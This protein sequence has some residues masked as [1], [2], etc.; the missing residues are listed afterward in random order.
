M[1]GDRTMHND[2][3]LG[4]LPNFLIAGMMKCGTTAL[5]ECLRRHPDVFMPADEVHFFNRDKFYARGIDL[6]RATFAEWRGERAIG[7]KTPGYGFNPQVAA[8][9]A[10]TLPDVK[11][12]WI[13]RAP[14]ARA[15]SHYWF[16]AGQ[17]WERLSFGD[18][19]A[20][21]PRRLASTRAPLYMK[22]NHAYRTLG[23]YAQLLQPFLD[24]I[25]RERQLFLR[26]ED[27]A[28]AQEEF[29]ARIYAFLDL[30][31]HADFALP[32]KPVNAT[33][34]PYSIRLQWLVT[35]GLAR[36]FPKAPRLHV[37][38]FKTM[39]RINLHTT[40]GYPPLDPALRAE[41]DGY[42]APH[43]RA[44]RDLTGIEWAARPGA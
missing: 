35:R 29:L 36:L 42:Y 13:L 40:P 44:L 34:R 18:A 43:N 41:L 24:A 31:P 8:R 30:D 33:Y 27:F 4:P 39:Q 14:T 5:A 25:G 7:E 16:A 28:V 26:Y 1:I 19:L 10:A 2:E 23:C 37:Q 12:I 3:A 11:L 17:G 21:E 22:A 15:Y 20:A 6:Y 38:V 32:D 9:I